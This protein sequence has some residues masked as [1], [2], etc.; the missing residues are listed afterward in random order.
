MS[1][2]SLP[3]IKALEGATNLSFE[4]GQASLARWNPGVRAATDA[5]DTISIYDVIGADPWT[6][7]GVSAKRIA[8]A[9]RSIG[10]KDVVVNLNSPGG[11]FFEGIA[12]YNLLREHAGKVTV[13]VMGL[14]ASAASVIAMAGD[15]IEISSVGFLMVHN[16]WAIAIGNQHDM[17][18][19]A[20][21][22]AP[23]DDAMAGLYAARAKVDKSVAAGWMD[24][25]TWFNGAQAIDA[26]LADALLPND[27]LAESDEPAAKA[28][29]ASRQIEAALRAYGYSRGQARGL[30]QE[31]RGMPGAA[32]NAK[33]SAGDV[34]AADLLR[35]AKTIRGE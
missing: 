11:D 20:E 10:A 1:I 17:R 27:Q 15:A 18:A 5:A 4:P 12:I 30:L 22:L 21:T 24:K 32:A 6:G 16:A 19:A 33:P 14:A 35:L 8:A 34:T 9:L 28:L 29:N 25:E 13:K 26:G 31:S 23:F 2:R 7:E 3:Q